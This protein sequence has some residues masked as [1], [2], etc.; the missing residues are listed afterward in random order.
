VTP[1]SAYNRARRDAM[2]LEERREMWRREKRTYRANLPENLRRIEGR[3][4]TALYRARKA[5]KARDVA[6]VAALLER[7]ASR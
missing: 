5:Q 4:A 3:E 6:D 2:T 7:R 1:K